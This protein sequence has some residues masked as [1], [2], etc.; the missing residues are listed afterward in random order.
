MNIVGFNLE[1]TVKDL[2]LNDGGVCIISNG[3]MHA[4][5]E[6]R[7]TRKKNDSGYEESLKYCLD[8]AGISIDEVDLFVLSSCCEVA[9]SSDNIEIEGVPQEKIHVIKSHHLS[10]AY[11][12]FMTSEFEESIILVLDNEGNITDGNNNPEFFKNES[13]K[14][15][16]YIGKG[17]KIDFFERDVVKIGQIGVGDAYRY[18]T[19][20]IGF[21]SYTYAGKTMGLAP[22]GNSETFKDVK[23]FDFIDGKISCRIKEKYFDPCTAIDEFFKDEYRIELEGSRKPFESLSQQHKDLAFLI[24]RETEEIIM[25]KVQYLIDKTGIKNICIA[26][27]VGLN[28][29]ANGR[30][31][32]ETDAES[33]HVT[34]AAGDSGQCLGNALYGY[35]ELKGETERF[36]LKNSYLGRVYEDEYIKNIIDEEAM[37]NTIEYALYDDFYLLSQKIADILSNNLIVANF[38]GG[39][40]FGPRS[41]GNRSILMSPI[42]A[43]NKDILNA[44]VKFREPFRPFAPSVLKEKT[45][46]YFDINVES[47]FMLLTAD[48]KRKDLIPAITHVDGSARLQTVDILENPRYYQIIKSFGERTGVDVVLNTSFNI[49]GEPIVESPEDAIRC[50]LGTNIDY[51][52]M[53]N[54]LIEKVNKE[55]ISFF[56]AKGRLLEEAL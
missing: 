26:G 52:I 13:E 12:S 3:K 19:H 53:G 51:L 1:K 35:H 43:E 33:I 38:Q 29:V 18:F 25:K 10:H 48:V 44:R 49:A 8:T 21:P 23:I 28:C 39:S 56:D 40:E 32:K 27:G 30:I 36:V 7:L 16:F 15:S 54:Y 11:S 55:E 4:I 5:A 2:P 6:E 9:R 17:N 41:L 42:M 14:M 34:P 45:S 50:F 20:Y 24:Q 47:P 31:L 37:N 22:Y 46:E